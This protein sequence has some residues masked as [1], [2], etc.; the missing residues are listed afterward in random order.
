M[1]FQNYV[2]LRFN[3]RFFRVKISFW[4]NVPQKIKNAQNW[5]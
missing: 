5:A 2:Y 1:M 4:Y 3:F